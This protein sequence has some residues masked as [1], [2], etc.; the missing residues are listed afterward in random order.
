MIPNDFP[1]FRDSRVGCP[2][3]SG[4]PGLS[5]GAGLFLSGMLTESTPKKQERMNRYGR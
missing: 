5:A 1:A 2:P 4:L 3:E